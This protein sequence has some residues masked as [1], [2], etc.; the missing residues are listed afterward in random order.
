MMVWR[1]LP[2]SRV[3]LAAALLFGAATLVPAGGCLD[4]SC[5][6][7]ACYSEVWAFS[8]LGTPLDQPVRLLVR[9]CRYGDC[10]EVQISSENVGE[11]IFLPR[12]M[13]AVSLSDGSLGLEHGSP[14]V[15]DRWVLAVE[16]GTSGEAT[17][18]DLIEIT[19]TD[20][21]TGNVSSV[22]EVVQYRSYERGCNDCKEASFQFPPP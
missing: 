17:D 6:L 9:A 20:E 1:L 21:A 15:G 4:E 3:V 11:A 19:V 5:S 14:G 18:G 22:S 8:T 13:V 2:G 12:E 16:Y 7:V 10:G